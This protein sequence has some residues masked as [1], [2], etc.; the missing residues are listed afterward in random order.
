MFT[1]DVPTGP[2]RGDGSPPWGIYSRNARFNRPCGERLCMTTGESETCTVGGQGRGPL[3]AS[4]DG[5]S[6]C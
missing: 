2:P 4:T 6:K 5:A 3:L 1:D